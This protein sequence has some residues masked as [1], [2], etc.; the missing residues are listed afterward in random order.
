MKPP[1]SPKVRSFQKYFSDFYFQV[2]AGGKAARSGVIEGYVI[3]KVNGEEF[4]NLTHHEAQ[5]KIKGAGH[6]LS[7]TLRQAESFRF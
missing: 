7:L 6:S 3:E 5:N 1:K 2:T 4:S